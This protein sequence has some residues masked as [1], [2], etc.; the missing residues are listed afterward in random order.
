MLIANGRVC[1]VIWTCTGR[2]SGPLV[3]LQTRRDTYDA[4]I[5]GYADT[6]AAVS[7]DIA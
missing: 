7:I 1:F 5:D 3:G 6:S 4:D 2:L